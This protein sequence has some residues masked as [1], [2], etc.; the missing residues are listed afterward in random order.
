[1]AQR[2]LLLGQEIRWVHSDRLDR[3]SAPPLVFWSGLLESPTC[4]ASDVFSS[5][6]ACAMRR[7]S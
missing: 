2:Q 3:L 1:M 5:L 6:P 4:R 7:V